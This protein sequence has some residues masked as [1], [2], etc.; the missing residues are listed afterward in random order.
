VTASAS[1]EEDSFEISKPSAN[2]G[3]DFIEVLTR[4][5]RDA[6]EDHGGVFDPDFDEEDFKGDGRTVNNIVGNLQY[7]FICSS[8]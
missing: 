6:E 4:E 3:I 2:S 5:T 7:L 1:T 8:S